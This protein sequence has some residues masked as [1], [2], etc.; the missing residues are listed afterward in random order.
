MN[1]TKINK[2][3]KLIVTLEGR[4]DTITA[5]QLQGELLPLFETNK[6]IVLNFENLAYISS[7]GLRVL[8]LGEKTAKSSNAKMTI[9]AVPESIMDVLEMTGFSEIL[10]IV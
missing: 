3:D 10:N 1:I 5:P 9:T 7:A 4:L 8:L 6:A 2:D